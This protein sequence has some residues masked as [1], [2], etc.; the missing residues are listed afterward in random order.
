MNGGA[1]AILAGPLYLHG[2][3]L[4]Q[5][6]DACQQ[7]NC[8]YY[9]AN[10][11]VTITPRG[12]EIEGARV[13]VLLNKNTGM[14]GYPSYDRAGLQVTAFYQPVFDTGVP[15]EVESLVF[16]ASGRWFPYSMTHVLDGNTP[17]GKWESRLL[18]LKAFV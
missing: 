5:L 16:G 11:T 7:A 1:N 10:D 15:I 12:R 4:D 2:T 3:L 17:Q 6:D 18:C 9:L 8:D 14:I 13:A